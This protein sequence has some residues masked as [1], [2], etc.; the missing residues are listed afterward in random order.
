MSTDI[1]T[2]TVGAAPAEVQVFTG[3]APILTRSSTFFAA[4]L[5][6]DSAFTEATDRHVR[7]PEVLP[8][9]F[10]H[11]LQWAYSSGC[12][13]RFTEN[14]PFRR[15]AELDGTRDTAVGPSSG[16]N[17]GGA[18]DPSS[19]AKRDD[20]S[21][22]WPADDPSSLDPEF[23][24]P[25]SYLHED[26]AAY[27]GRLRKYGRPL[28]PE[29]RY[30]SLANF[31]PITDH[32]AAG[33][34]Q[35]KATNGDS[36]AAAAPSGSPGAKNDTD[37]GSSARKPRYLPRFWPYVRLYQV[38]EYLGSEGCMNACVDQVAE[39]AWAFNAVP[40]VQDVRRLWGDDGTE[41]GAV[42]RG[43]DPGR[44]N[45]LDTATGLQSLVLDLFVAR[46]T[47]ALVLHEAEPWCVFIRL[48]GDCVSPAWG[49]D[50]DVCFRRAPRFMRELFARIK[51]C[52]RLRPDDPDRPDG[53]LADGVLFRCRRYHTHTPGQTRSCFNKS[54]G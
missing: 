52:Q 16:D 47:E 42:P 41:T 38:A 40:G 44:A 48:L 19:K 34:R 5:N 1:V 39:L 46:R 10:A 28:P 9:T 7:L 14:N 27:V 53:I 3:H 51:R 25:N 15:S 26:V 30:P 11:W 23:L 2:I 4:A 20:G 54:G 50:A 49:R 36:P 37:S 12:D 18:V 29:E 21:K 32:A 43:A 17:I 8:D 22:A 45:G 35:D 31:R 6:P 33:R 13:L 24:R